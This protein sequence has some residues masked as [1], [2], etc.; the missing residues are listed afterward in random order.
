M[1]ADSDDPTFIEEQRH[2]SEIYAQ[3]RDIYDE[4][5]EEIE[6]KHKS[7]AQDLRD[8]SEEVRIDFGGADETMET[9]AAIE[10]LNSV[11]DTY[12]QHHDF[13]V[14]KL[15][16]VI[17]LM[18]QPYFAKVR[19]K[20]RPGRPA[21]DVYIGSA[22]ITDKN[23][24]PLI[25]DW[26]NPVAET[27]YNQEMGPTSYTVD[28]RVRTVNLELRRQYDIVRDKLNAYFDTTIAIEDSL[29]LNALKR[30][31][32][33]K[34]QAITATIQKEQNQVVR[35]EDVP[36]MLVN[37]IAGSG[38][39]SVL[40]QRIAFLFYRN[41]ETLSPEQVYLFTPNQVF[42]KYID[43]VLPTLGESNP[44]TFTWKEFLA[45]LGL[46]DRGTGAEEDPAVL[47]ELDAAF[48]DVQIKMEDL[49]D[50]RVGETALIKASQ[51]KS[52]LE[53]FSQFPVGPRLMAL[54]RDE[55]H[56]RLDRRIAQMAHGEEVL[57]EVL[58]L[59]VD[60]QMELFG[61]VASPSNDDD[62][63]RYAKKLLKSRYDCA[64]EDIE[65]LTWLRL[66]RIGCR[67]TGR[68]A[69]SAAEWLYLKLLVTGHGADD[70][71]F[72]MI[73]EV[74]DYTLT[75]LTVLAKYFPRAHFLLLGDSH[76]AIHEGTATFEQIRELFARTHGNVEECRLMTSYRSSPEITR[77]F[78]SLLPEEER[79][80]LSSV[81]RPGIAPRVVEVADGETNTQAWLDELRSAIDAAAQD[82]GLTAVVAAD[83]RRVSWLSKQLGERVVTVRNGK[84]LPAEGV[85][86]MD[87]PLAKG[88]EFD[89]VIVPDAQETV[90]PDTP[91]ARRRLYTA[92]SRAMH[93]VDLISQGGISPLLAD[94]K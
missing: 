10:T 7:A 70:A 42:Q 74:Q 9:L 53:K 67:M 35:H 80:N 16:R 63:F 11:I 91:L 64:H 86:L 85:V 82:E 17:M 49:R 75:Q 57:E 2:L 23:K 72:V 58:A 47:D 69:I 66:D 81:H 8:L 71:R 36:V 15:G 1:A 43:T 25:V 21:R 83:K 14:E 22:G 87:L 45:G 84:K 88:L 44:Q 92:I 28:G 3:L 59:D 38:K 62:A 18:G 34:L 94:W 79:I 51:I 37:G 73:D 76:Q 46:G 29:L 52:A 90:Y 40:L 33:E 48:G 20:M 41:R 12:N 6:V 5:T 56:D 89:H 31:H 68:K 54:V 32:T 55:L 27:Y 26:R 13:A 65:N 30:H 61:E 19:L 60:E 39:T 24:I 78:A 77:L 93:K 50:I 4:L